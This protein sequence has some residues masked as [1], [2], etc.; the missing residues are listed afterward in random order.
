MIG[1][2]AAPVGG[3]G[4][5]ESRGK[6]WAE[7]LIARCRTSNWYRAAARGDDPSA[8]WHLG[9]LP[10]DG[11]GVPR[12]SERAVDLLQPAAVGTAEVGATLGHLDT[13]GGA[14][15]RLTSVVL[16]E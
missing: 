3:C 11:L 7:T 5:D 14:A 6:S 1:S 13:M 8:V 16:A 9:G 4:E 15:E 10:L 12:N 2:G